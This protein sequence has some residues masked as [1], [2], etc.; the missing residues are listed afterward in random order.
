LLNAPGLNG[1]SAAFCVMATLVVLSKARSG[2]PAQAVDVSVSIPP[3]FD[4]Y[5][6]RTSSGA[7]S[8]VHGK[9]PQPPVAGLV[10]SAFLVLPSAASSEARP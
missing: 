10:R 2:V 4:V 5:V 8:S 1:E 9:P 6:P 3:K 7:K